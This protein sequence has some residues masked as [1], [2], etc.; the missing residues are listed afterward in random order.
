LKERLVKVETELG[1][2]R[3]GC[4]TMFHA[5][6]LNG[7]LVAGEPAKAAGPDKRLEA[8]QDFD[9]LLWQ[10]KQGEKGPFQQ[11]SEKATGNSDLWKVLRAK[12]KEHNGFWQNQ[13]YK[14]WFDMQQ[15][16]V[17]DRRKVA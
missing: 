2:L 16:T 12:L 14:Y 3:A 1:V 13:G 17:I 8:K 4:E 6:E 9:K 5:L 11:T 15:E 7:L 10:D